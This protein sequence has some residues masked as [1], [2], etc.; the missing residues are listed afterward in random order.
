VSTPDDRAARAGEDGRGV[1]RHFE[2]SADEYFRRHSGE[3]GPGGGLLASYLDA[4]RPHLRGA[5]AL[6]A[7][8]GPGNFAHRVG[9]ERGGLVIGV[10]FSRAMLRMARGRFRE[11]P[12]AAGD[13]R[14]LPFRSGAFDLA[15]SFRSLQHVPDLEAALRELVR[16]VAGG[17]HVVFD[18]V[19][20]RNLLGFLREKASGRKGRIYLKAHTHRSLRALCRRV[21]LEPVERRAIQLFPDRGNIEKRLGSSLAGWLGPL[22]ER[23]DRSARRWPVIEKLALRS[24]I[25]ARKSPPAGA[26][27]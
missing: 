23:V 7:G 12:V 26:A 8:C 22:I 4:L 5:A 27:R 21:G 16:V 19:N 3:G 13:L 2:D 1:R 11:V 25:V 6:D 18:Y 10:D 14:R 17:G 15:Y 24:L 9:A 20:R